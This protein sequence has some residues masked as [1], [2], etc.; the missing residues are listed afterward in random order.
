M[1]G[2]IYLEYVCVRRMVRAA[3]LEPAKPLGPADFKSAAFTNF[4]TPA[5]RVAT[6]LEPVKQG[7]SA[8]L[9]LA[10]HPIAGFTH[11]W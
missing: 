9:K 10:Q 11:P 7:S 2:Q 8:A 3:G 5:M 6:G 4:A 1:P